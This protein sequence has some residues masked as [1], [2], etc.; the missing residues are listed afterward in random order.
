M[1]L[2]LKF[3]L[4]LIILGVLNSCGNS[5][6]EKYNSSIQFLVENGQRPDFSH[7]GKKILY[8]TKAAGEV[9]EIDIES[10]EIKRISSFERPDSIGFFRALYLA[11]GDYLLAGGKDRR[12][13]VFYFLKKELN[14]PPYI[15]NEPLWEG[16]A[17]SRK[18]MRIAW[19][20]DHFTI[21]TGEI[22]SN[23][24]G[25]AIV[26]R[27]LILESEKIEADGQK[28]NDWIEPQNFRPPYENELIFAQYGR[29]EIFTSE[30]F[31]INLL[32][33]KITNYSKALKQYDEPEGIFPNGEYTLIESDAHNPK[34][35]PYI[36]IYMLK[37]DGSGKNTKRLTFF[38]TH[39]GQIS[40]NPVISDD[41]KFMAF[42][43]GAGLTDT[44]EGMKIGI[45][46]M[47][48]QKAGIKT[49]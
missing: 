23:D 9:E 17:V 13:C 6:K 14:Q 26:N 28:F 38:N 4:V 42:D 36:D 2:P 35:V 33:G 34:G 44:D 21:W 5:S 12:G 40:S 3:P 43:N 16:P 8:V 29:E 19:T 1:N 49:K 47:D 20:P 11:N 45:Y 27:K 37:L 7:D 30:V 18:N 39:Q 10:G 41:G 32:D 15:I 25:Y 48:L 31:G 24:S 46:L 22:V